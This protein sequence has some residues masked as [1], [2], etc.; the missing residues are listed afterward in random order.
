[1]LQIFFFLLSFTI[2]LFHKADL[3]VVSLLKMTLPCSKGRFLPNSV[4]VVF[5]LRS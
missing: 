4:K 5:G 1:M 3:T 2:F